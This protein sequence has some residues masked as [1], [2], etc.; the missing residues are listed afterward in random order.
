MTTLGVKDWLSFAG[1]AWIRTFDRGGGVAATDRDV[2]L[3][4]PVLAVLGT[5]T[6]NAPAWLC[7]GQ[8]LQAVLLEARTEEVWASFLN[9]PIEV[10]DL[11]SRLAETVGRGPY[12]QVLLRLGYGSEV[13]P[14]PR[15]SVREVV[16]EHKS[17][18]G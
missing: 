15:R 2:A 16:M 4:S 9:Q 18:H 12:P 1:P 17:A 11:R 6:D 3:H 7:A 13:A 5:E 14:T 10:P 8:A